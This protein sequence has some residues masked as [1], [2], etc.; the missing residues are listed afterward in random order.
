[1]TNLAQQTAYIRRSYWENQ[2]LDTRM[3]IRE[4]TTQVCQG[5]HIYFWDLKVLGDES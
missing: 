1:M 5:Y 3:T 4:V 2:E